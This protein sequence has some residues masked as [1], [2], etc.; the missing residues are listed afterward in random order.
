MGDSITDMSAFVESR[1]TVRFS[2]CD[3]DSLSTVSSVND[4]PS[5]IPKPRGEAGRPQSGGYNLQETL[6]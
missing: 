5:L 4:A 3:D 2:E 1:P 6:G